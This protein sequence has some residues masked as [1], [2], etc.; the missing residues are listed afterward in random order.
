M[1]KLNFGVIGSHTLHFKYSFY[2]SVLNF[3]DK[4]FSFFTKKKILSFTSGIW[5]G[6]LFIVRE[7]LKLQHEISKMLF[8][9]VRKFWDLHDYNCK[10]L[11]FRKLTKIGLLQIEFHFFVFL[12]AQNYCCSEL[13]RETIN[14]F[15]QITL[16][17]VSSLSFGA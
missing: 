16:K 3:R 13:P 8:T 11:K 7:P 15:F 5:E 9:Y 4:S 17:N 14:P 1:Y 10:N 2:F 6:D 12:N